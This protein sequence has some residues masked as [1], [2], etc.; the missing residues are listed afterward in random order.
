MSQSEVNHTPGKLPYWA[1]VTADTLNVREGPGTGY[2]IV[3]SIHRPKIYTIIE[4]DGNWGLLKSF[5]ANRN[6]WIN[7]TYTERVETLS[8]G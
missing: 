7:L 4:E 6:G 1:K 8:G 3:T 5:S 2:K